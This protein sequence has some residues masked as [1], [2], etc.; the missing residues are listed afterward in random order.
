EVVFDL[1]NIDSINF[2]ETSMKNTDISTSEFN[3]IMV[4][5]ENL[6]GCT[7]SRYQAVYFATL[8]GLKIK[9]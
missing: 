5:M 8:L 2:R 9:E 4:S 1:C 7:V 3:S 6:K